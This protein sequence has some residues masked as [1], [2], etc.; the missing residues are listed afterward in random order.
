MNIFLQPAGDVAKK[1]LQITIYK[2]EKLDNLKEYIT[3]EQY[4]ELSKLYPNKELNMWG[5]TLKK[6]NVWKQM[7]IGDLV[8]FYGNRKFFVKGSILYKIHNI[9]LAKNI[10]GTDSKELCWEYIFFL[11]N[12]QNINISLEEFNSITGYNFKHVQGAMKVQRNN[13]EK[14]LEKYKDI[15]NIDYEEVKYHEEKTKIPK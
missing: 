10:W 8:L 5:V 13:T 15:F 6:E 7:K 9:K 14:I 11:D 4:N 2:K 3:V 1:Q 12:A